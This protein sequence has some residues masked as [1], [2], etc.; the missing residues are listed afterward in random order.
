MP[1][2]KLRTLL[3]HRWPELVD[4]LDETKHEWVRSDRDP[5]VLERRRALWEEL[6]SVEVEI[7][8]LMDQLAR[9]D[10]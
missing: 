1:E 8:A 6:A 4:Q 5:S 3:E 2:L 7:E 10:S 9:R